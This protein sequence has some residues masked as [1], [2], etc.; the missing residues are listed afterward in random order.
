MLDKI[1]INI[2]LL[3]KHLS[4]YMELR[5]AGQA[6]F[7][8]IILL[9]S[10]NGIGAIQSNFKLQEQVNQ[11]NQQN[12]LANLQNEDIALQ[13][14]YYQSKQYLDLSARQNLGLALPGETE[15]LVPDSVALTYTVTQP[16]DQSTNTQSQPKSQQNFSS[17]IDFFLHR[18]N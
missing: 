12:E 6:V 4:K 16:S 14:Q 3:P 1:K 8:V 9:I 7:V 15:L 2:E 5:Y 11:L 17:W 10:W 13:N 18:N